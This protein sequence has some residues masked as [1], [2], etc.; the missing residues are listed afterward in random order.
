VTPRVLVDICIW[1]A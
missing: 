1:L